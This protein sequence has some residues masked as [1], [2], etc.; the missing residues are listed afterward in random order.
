[1]WEPQVYNFSPWILAKITIGVVHLSS[2]CRPEATT[3]ASILDPSHGTL[4]IK[5]LVLF[6]DREGTALV[7]SGQNNLW[8]ERLPGFPPHFP[9]I[10]LFYPAG[11]NG[12]EKN[13]ETC[14]IHVPFLEL[15]SALDWK[16]EIVSPTSQRREH[17]LNHKNPKLPRNYITK[18][19]KQQPNSGILSPSP[20]L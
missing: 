15:D 6:R 3:G 9:G 5:T 7:S 20:L 12:N 10:L 13:G 1:M 16:M 14:L 18:P 11:K 19:P 2:E 8:E 4:G 17:T